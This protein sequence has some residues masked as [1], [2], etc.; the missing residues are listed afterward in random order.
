MGRI[1]LAPARRGHGVV[2]LLT[3]RLLGWVCPDPMVVAL[4]PSSIALNEKQHEDEAAFSPGMAKARW[5]WKSVGFRPFGEDI[6][7]IMNHAMAD[8]DEAVET[9]ARKL[10]LPS[11]QAAAI[12]HPRLACPANLKLFPRIQAGRCLQGSQTVPGHFHRTPGAA[13]TYRVADTLP[14]PAAVTYT[15]TGSG[16]GSGL[17]LFAPMFACVCSDASVRAGRTRYPRH[18]ASLDTGLA[19][20]PLSA[21]LIIAAPLSRRLTIAFG[22]RAAMAVG[23]G[24]LP[25]D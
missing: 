23:M 22:A 19:L 15:F 21:G 6:M 20:I 8:H 5:T 3:A 16:H 10:G 2:R 14:L 25:A 9:L 13:S 18:S 12:A 17:G 7:I 1:R 11:D 4:M 24:L